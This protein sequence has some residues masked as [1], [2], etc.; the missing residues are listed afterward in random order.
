MNLQ[1]NLKRQRQRSIAQDL[2]LTLVIITVIVFAAI[3]AITYFSFTSTVR[4]DLNERAVRHA[5]NLADVLALPLWNVNTT[6]VEQIGAVYEQAEDVVHVRVFDDADEVIYET[7]T[8]EIFTRTFTEKRDISF[9][10]QHVGVAEL[11]FSLDALSTAQ[12]NVLLLTTAILIPLILAIVISTQ[13]V[14]R[15]FVVKPLDQLADGIENIASG[16]YEFRLPGMSQVETDFIAERANDMAE[17]IKE[18]DYALRELIVNLEDRISERTRDLDLAAEIGRRVSQMHDTQMMLTEAV[19]LIRDRF[20]LYHVQIYLVDTINYVL[21]LRA[22]T[23]AVGDQ[24]LEQGHQLLIDTNSLNGLAVCEKRTV[25]VSDTVANPMFKPHE[26]LPDTKAEVVIP[27]IVGE[28]IVGV[29]DLQSA[30]VNALSQD[31]LPAIEVLAAQL[32]VAID[33]AML[34]ENQQRL[35]AEMEENSLF[36]DS[37][38]EN[39]PVMLFVKDAEELRFQIWNQVTEDLFGISKE[40]TLGKNDYDLFSKEDAEY[41]TSEDRK[42]LNSRELQLIPEETIQTRDKGERILRTSKV[43]ILGSD[44]EP[45]YLLGISLDITDQK[46]AEYALA[47]RVAELN[48]LNDIGR[49]VE[50]GMPVP[51]FMEWVAARIEPVFKQSSSFMTAVK[52]DEAIYG[53]TEAIS[54]KR[55]IVEGLYI[56][57]EFVGNLY[58]AYSDESL[59]FAD[60]DSSF[61]GAV[62]GRLSSYMDSRSLLGQLE[63]QATSLQQVAEIGTAVSTI[64]DPQELMQTFV[65][66]T[67]DEF[68]LYHA[69]IYLFDVS[70]DM[71]QLVA[72]AGDIGRNMVAERRQ[73]A[74]EQ[75][76]SLV[77][78]AARS[79][80]GVIVN[81]V[82]NEPGFLPH[83]LLPDTRSE[84]AVPLI[85]FDQLLGVLDVQANT[86][87]AFSQADVSIF[88]T[89]ATQVAVALQNADQYKETQ[90]TLEEVS[91][92]QRAMTRQGW[93]GFL[94]AKEKTVYGFMADRANVNP[95]TKSTDSAKVN[96]VP[97]QEVRE[98]E[99]AVF[100]PVQLG[101]ASIGS[102]GVRTSNEKELSTEQN[103][104][105]QAISEQ[106][107][108]ALERARLFEET[109]IARTQ[110]E[111]LYASSSQIVRAT[112]IDEA[113]DALVQSSKLRQFSRTAFLSFDQPWTD[114]QPEKLTMNVVHE[115]SDIPYIS[116]LAEEYFL[117]TL[118]FTP[119]L[120]RD[121][122]VIV[123]D[124][125]T[126]GHATDEMRDFFENH[127]KTRSII[128]FPMV[129]GDEWFGIMAADH[130]DAMPLTPEE[131]RQISSLT[132]QTATVVQSLRLFEAAEERAAELAIINDVVS[133]VTSTLEIEESLQ[134]VS[135]EIAKIIGNEQVS[136]ALMNKD[137]KSLTII[138]EVFDSENVASTIGYQIPVEG[139]LLTQEVLKTRQTV[140][141]EDAQNSPLTEPVREGMILKGVQTLYVIPMLAGNEV[142]GT[143]GIDIL[144]KDRLLSE[145]QLRLAETLIFQAATAVQN[146]RL[147]SESQ[148]RADELS[149]INSISEVAS[150]QLNTS[151]L[152]NSVGTLMHEMF[153]AESVYFAMYDKVNSMISF[154]YFYS[155]DEGRYDVEPRA[156]DNGGFTAQI[157]ESK[158][159]LRHLLQ[160]EE[161][162]DGVKV[163][164]A[165]VVGT[166]RLADSYV[167]VPMIVGREVIGVIGVSNYSEIRTYSEQDQRLL[168]SLAGTIGV[169]VQNSRQ[170]EEAQRRAERESLINTISQKIQ[171]A[172]TV[173]SALQ[174]AVSELGQAL[175]LK[176]AVVELSRTTNGNGES[177]E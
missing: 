9:E 150:S 117:D 23:G 158:K 21:D 118:P 114:V 131:I 134:I 137:Q 151:E 125:T 160:Q 55:Q 132:D 159:S 174:T 40:E 161:G 95:I 126:F 37:I 170:F 108:Q 109:E 157:I 139:N 119:F 24:M 90:Q 81:D 93:E 3:G 63:T 106:V 129:V 68:D 78:L 133:T 73:I 13:F 56:G 17:Q 47:R 53:K 20:D 145:Q 5:D 72:G 38:I 77:A 169:A 44:G 82:Q 89:L 172:T 173:E 123:E 60:E 45:K 128:L 71:L 6:S 138:A 10:G 121:E 36:L 14:V 25:V 52:I 22:S 42:V 7:E 171:S 59:T 57:D 46:S 110:T 127:L 15:R 153:N 18:R 88:T 112:T 124:I 48:C 105:L 80:Q 86:V 100:T 67:K 75:K 156:M 144:H 99:T 79:Y 97:L 142:V 167:G 29:L 74:Y 35:T 87:D 164:G 92:L 135:K 122:P 165:Q 155:K 85:V 94:T 101:A 102:I 27:L 16:E 166:G 30:D 96:A 147:Y 152:F 162:Q 149:M 4:V 65:D 19:R 32:A 91:A 31:S 50:Q 12:R 154:P 176:K 98:D 1:A 107:G 177:R 51:D 69:H 175:R 34:F 43:P 26:L 83:P 113:L 62:G 141:V 76:Q 41:F 54:Q 168:E 84:M 163:E 130:L 28:Q 58:F 104:L 136:I 115:K 2:T 8:N 143:V 146:A 49:K 120:K 61:I 39:L 70:T 66:R 11:T 140:I 111:S 33:S 64:L 148:E 103:E 116:D